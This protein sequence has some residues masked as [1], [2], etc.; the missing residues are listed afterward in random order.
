M[1]TSRNL[2]KAL[3]TVAPNEKRLSWFLLIM[4]SIASKTFFHKYVLHTFQPVG[5]PTRKPDIFHLRI[6]FDES[7]K[8]VM[9]TPDQI[10]SNQP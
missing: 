8:Q 6:M 2:L 4:L 5:E 9:G 7:K 10:N 3:D 1:N